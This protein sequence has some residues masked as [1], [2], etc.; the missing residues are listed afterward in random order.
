MLSEPLENAFA[1]RMQGSGGLQPKYVDARGL[2]RRA[3]RNNRIAAIDR[4]LRQSQV[5]H[6]DTWS[7]ARRIHRQFIQIEGDVPVAVRN[8]LTVGLQSGVARGPLWGRLLAEMASGGQSALLTAVL[9]NA[10][11]SWVPPQP[12]FDIGASMR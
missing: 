9:N 8:R 10:K 11:S 12:F 1:R 6:C 7:T 3:G 2:Q 4:V 5:S